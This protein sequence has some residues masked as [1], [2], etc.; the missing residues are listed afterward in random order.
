MNESGI[1]FGRKNQVKEWNGL[2]KLGPFQKTLTLT[3]E[4]LIPKPI[5]FLP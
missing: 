4:K 1:G 2:K 3:K 5:T